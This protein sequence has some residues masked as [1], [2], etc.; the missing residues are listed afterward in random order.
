MTEVPDRDGEAV[1]VDSTVV[2]PVAEPL[3]PYVVVIVLVA[4]VIVTQAALPERPWTRLLQVAVL[5][6]TLVAALALGRVVRRL[7]IA[8]GAWIAVVALSALVIDVSGELD[9]RAA[10]IVL[11]A[12]G[13]LVALAPLAILAAVRRL[14]RITAHTVLAA[15]SIYLLIGSFF[16]FIYRAIEQ[17]SPGSFVD[18]ERALEPAAFQYLSFIT[19]TTVGFG[20]VR[21]VSQL[22]RTVTMTEGLI[23]QLYLVT[24]VALVVGN[25]GQQVRRRPSPPST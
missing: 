5:G 24:V 3:R 15:V 14:H 17:F 1:E 22:A 25:L 21:P 12:N 16:A 7:R 13:L 6:A 19:L 20:D 10:G 11:L 8:A 23:G 9:D 2:D 18:P 4:S